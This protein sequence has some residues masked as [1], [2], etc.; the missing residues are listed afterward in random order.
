MKFTSPFSFELPTV[1]EFGE[2][3][4]RRL[5]EFL[6]RIGAKRPLIITDKGLA[7]LSWFA[8]IVEDLRR[9]GLVAAV[10]DAVEPNPK[11]YNVE[12]A[13]AAARFHA[14]DCLIAVGGGSPI[15]CAKAA[16]IIAV[17]G[18]R[19]RD[20]EDRSRI[21]E[22]VLPLIS[23]PTTAGTGSEVTFS[24]VITDSREKIKFTVFSIEYVT[25]SLHITVWKVPVRGRR[26]YCK[27]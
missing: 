22:T 8:A 26:I 15:D 23:V 7:A 27:P 24:S 12:D 17:Q 16:G 3:S 9:D 11:D 6:R 19:A 21:G 10:F 14:A 1:I 18:G 25:P 2:G 20:Y 4:S 13:A 5:P